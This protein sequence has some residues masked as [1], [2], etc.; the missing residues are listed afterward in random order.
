MIKQTGNLIKV[1][2]VPVSGANA[3]VVV[4][5]HN[6]EDRSYSDSTE[7]RLNTFVGSFAIVDFSSETRPLCTPV[8]I[9]L[10]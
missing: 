10:I 3:I 5:S 2:P 7:M 1:E 9:D 8:S 4:K 6:P